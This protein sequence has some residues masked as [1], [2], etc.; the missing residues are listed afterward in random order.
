MPK[1][2]YINLVYIS[3]V[4]LESANQKFEIPK[5]QA[6]YNERSAS[7]TIS[8]LATVF[9]EVSGSEASQRSVDSRSLW[10][11]AMKCISG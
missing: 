6:E 1:G 5:P 9:L 11:M 8:K 10:E 4:I 2:D 3:S 7:T